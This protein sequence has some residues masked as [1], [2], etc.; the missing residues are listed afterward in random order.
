MEQT[1]PFL[2]WGFIGVALILAL[3]I[4]PTAAVIRRRVRKQPLG[5][6]DWAVGIFWLLVIALAENLFG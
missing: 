2:F 1:D 3:A 5:S 4:W 6:L